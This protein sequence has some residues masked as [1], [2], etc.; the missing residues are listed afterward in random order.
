MKKL[1]VGLALFGSLASADFI[2]ASAG[3]GLWQ[4]NIDGYTK[5]GSDINYFTDNHGDP[6]AGYLNLGDAT[7][8]YVWAKIIHPIPFVPNVKAEYRQYHTTGTNGKVVGSI[9]VFGEK[10]SGAASPVNTDLTINSYDITFFYELKIFAEIEAGFGVNVLD[11]ETKLS[12]AVNSDTT[13][14]APIPYLYARGETPTI[15]GFS[16]EAQVKYLDIGTAFYHDY[17]ADVKYHLPFPIL[18]LTLSAGYKTQEIYAED[19]DNTTDIKF[20]GGFLEV[21]ARW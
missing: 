16:A 20:D 14:V 4:E 21:G 15:F 1:L 6:Q 2:G 19:G 10:V 7:K 11:G 18:D 12:G 3:A 9:S 13:W 8:P 5:S 17:Q